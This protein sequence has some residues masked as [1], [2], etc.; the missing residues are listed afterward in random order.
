LP[1]QK[2]GFKKAKLKID[3]R[4]LFH[5][6]EIDSSATMAEGMDST[7]NFCH[8]YMH[9]GFSVEKKNFSTEYSGAN[10]NLH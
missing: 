5:D 6:Q 10:G 1:K 4:L 8:V 2:E 9:S 7:E 3:Y